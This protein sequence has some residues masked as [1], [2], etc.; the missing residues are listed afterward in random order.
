[1]PVCINAGQVRLG[2]FSESGRI[3]LL[4]VVVDQRQPFFVDWQ[5]GRLVVRELRQAQEEGW[6][7]FLTWVVMPDH[8]HCLVQLRDKTLAELMCRI[9]SRSSLAVNQALGRR[10][11]MWQKGYH[12]RA[13]RREDDVKALARYVVANPIRAGLVTRVHDYPLW[14]ACW[15]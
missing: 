5:L 14:D 3:Y 15:L 12:D 4:T 2:R 10:G 6:G 13:V 11:R 8:M 9:K 1:M 7:D